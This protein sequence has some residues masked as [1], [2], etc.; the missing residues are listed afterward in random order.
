MAANLD[1]ALLAELCALPGVAGFEQ[2]VA[3]RLKEIF[4]EM[5]VDARRDRIG[6]LVAHLPGDGPRVMLFAHSDEVGL[7][8]RKIDAKGFVFVERLGGTS[9]HV[10]PGKKMLVWTATGPVTGV[11]GAMP[12]HLAGNGK[13]PEL[14][15]MYIDLGV[16]SRQQVEALGVEVGQQ[17]TY[18]PDLV[19]LNGCLGG[20]SL[21]DRLGCALLV[22]L[23]RRVLAQP[24]P[25]D[26]YLAFLVQEE[27]SFQAVIP[28]AN[29]IQPDYAI[30]LDATLA[31][32]TPDLA[33]GQTDLHLGGGVVVKVMDRIRGSG[34]GFVAH[35]ELRCHLEMLAKANNI[36]FQREIVI[37]LSTLASLL[38][39][40]GTGLPVAAISFPLRYAHSSFEVVDLEDIGAA[41]L[42]LELAVRQPWVFTDES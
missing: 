19:Q 35:P 41:Q 9:P 27:N 24:A 18:A 10:L 12:M 28:A 15:K 16:Y 4:A 30:G 37:G 3:G 29:A 31:F 5:G 21:D 13:Q 6:N 32:D 42:L 40:T 7:L 1:L 36:P 11:V 22:E 23:A 17:I 20:K 38:P 8:V 26:L 34:V 33:D 39:F 25:C 14:E 2:P